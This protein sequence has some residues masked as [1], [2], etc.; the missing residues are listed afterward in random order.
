M[1]SFCFSYWFMCLLR[2]MISSCFKLLFLMRF[3]SSSLLFLIISLASLSYFSSLVLISLI[4]SC[5]CL[6]SLLRCS[7]CCS[8]IWWFLKK[9]SLFLVVSRLCLKMSWM[10]L[11]SLFSIFSRRLSS[12]LVWLMRSCKEDMFFNSFSKLLETVFYESSIKRN[13]IRYIC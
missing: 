4:L 2:L 10:F 5:L 6:I 9:L 1:T 11:V 12:F 13:I 7:W 8:F 3:L